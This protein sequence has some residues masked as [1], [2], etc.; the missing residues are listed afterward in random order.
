MQAKTCSICGASMKRNGKTS[1]GAQRWRC[2]SCNASNVHRIDSTAKDLERFLK[3]L[4][5][6]ERHSDMPGGGRTFRRKTRRFWKLWPLPP[7]TGE[8]CRV[9]FVDG[10]YLSKQIVV[11]IAHSG[12][13]VIG[14][15]LARSENSRSWAA[16]LSKVTPPEVV[17]CDGGTGFEKA[18]KK[19]WPNTRVQRCTFHAF[20]QVKRC[21]TSRPRLSAGVELYGLAKDLLSIKTLHQADL[22]VE[23]LLNWCDFWNEFLEEKSQEDNK[24][25]YTHERLRKA[26]R[27]L[28]SLV[29][30]GTLFT[31]LDP[32]L[33]KEGPLPAMNNMI[34]GGVN[35]QLR[36][37]M[38]D[39]RGL[40]D[41]RRIKAIFWWCYMHTEYPMT[42]AEILRE[43]PTDDDIELLR[44]I[45]GIKINENIGPEKWGTGIVWEEFHHRTR[46]PYEFD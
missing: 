23:R 29:N 17:V 42:A 14:W 34:E 32:D 1:S 15:H 30:A 39:H 21:T 7:E 38:R 37:L 43:M 25:V 45:Y 26:R 44:D 12:D 36:A 6:R 22:W 16:L 27:G 40:S 31:Y 13:F 2:K 8:I 24:L 28:V 4:F 33:C 11:L 35:A 46:W 18:R 19:V 41:L 9:V 20:C 3:W 10:I 5:S